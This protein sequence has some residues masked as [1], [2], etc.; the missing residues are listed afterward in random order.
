MRQLLFYY[1]DYLLIA[2][3]WKFWDGY[4]CALSYLNLRT[5]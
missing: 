1:R 5:R 3:P 4:V 2:L